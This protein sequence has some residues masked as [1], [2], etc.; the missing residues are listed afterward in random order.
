MRWAVTVGD[1]S[2]TPQVVVASR[3]LAYYP[4]TPDT[5][6]RDI[7]LGVSQVAGIHQARR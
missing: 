6:D 5:A 4:L 7:E 1:H 3:S 2:H